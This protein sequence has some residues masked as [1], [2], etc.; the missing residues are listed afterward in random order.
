MYS[1]QVIRP[2]PNKI[3]NVGAERWILWIFEL[4]RERPL[5]IISAVKRIVNDVIRMC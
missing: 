4:K 1:K 2:Y 3:S 5:A